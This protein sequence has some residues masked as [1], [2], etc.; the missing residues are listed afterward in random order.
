MRLLSLALIALVLFQSTTGQ[1]IDST[2]AVH[3]NTI[4]SESNNSNGAGTN[5]F[6]GRNGQGNFRRGLIEFTSLMVHPD[7]VKSVSIRLHVNQISDVAA[8]HKFRI[9]KLNNSWGEGTSNS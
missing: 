7:S 3:D 6:A 9:H 2:V 8:P 4:F 5:M 1:I